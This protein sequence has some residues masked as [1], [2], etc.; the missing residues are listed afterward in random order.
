ML[1][2]RLMACVAGAA[3]TFTAGVA[4]AQTARPI[5]GHPAHAEI[6][7]FGFD[8]AGMDASVTPGADFNRYANGTYLR[9]T[10]IPGDKTSY[11]VFD[12]LYDRSQDN[13]RVLIDESAANPSASADAGRIG[14]FYG[15]FMDEAAVERLGAAPLQADLAE[16]RAA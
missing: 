9:N 4:T 13:L 3:L 10:P 1:R 6:G 15:S 5:A 16:V 2:L 12:M 14:A 7:A 8:Q 11:G